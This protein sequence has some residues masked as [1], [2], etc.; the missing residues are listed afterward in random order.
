MKSNALSWNPMEAFNFTVANEDQ[1]CYTFDMRNLKTA[2][3]VHTDHVAAVYVYGLST[4]S[5]K[6]LYI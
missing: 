6:R 4:K 2:L 3:K 1:N 5:P